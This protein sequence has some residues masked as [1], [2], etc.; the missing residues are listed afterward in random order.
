MAKKKKKYNPLKEVKSIT[1]TQIG[2]GIGS[3]LVGSFGGLTPHT[4]PGVYTASGMMGAI[5]LVQTGGS[6]IRS[7][8]LLKQPRKRRKRKR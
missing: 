7:F 6:V 3:G 5:P 8:D 4:P 2:V 1:A